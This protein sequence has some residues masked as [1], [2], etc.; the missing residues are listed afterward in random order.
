MLDESPEVT[1]IHQGNLIF[2]C[3]RNAAMWSL[4]S[5]ENKQGARTIT[6]IESAPGFKGVMSSTASP[7][8]E[9]VPRGT[10]LVMT[11]T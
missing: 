11:K 3:L 7:S 10:R 4:Y 2:T 6:N 9:I 5:S 8:I 1:N